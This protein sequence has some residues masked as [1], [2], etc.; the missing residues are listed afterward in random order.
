MAFDYK[1]KKERKK[2]IIVTVISIIIHTN[3][4]RKHRHALKTCIQVPEPHYFRIA[5]KG[6][7]E[8]SSNQLKKSE[9]RFNM[10]SLPTKF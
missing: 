8:K 1:K 4:R 5:T 6:N 10:V 3:T 7:G 9:A 2:D